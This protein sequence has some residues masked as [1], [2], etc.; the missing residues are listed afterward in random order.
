TTDVVLPVRSGWD[1]GAGFA[2]GGRAVCAAT[3]GTA[4]V[5]AAGAA[6]AGWSPPAAGLACG[7]VCG[8]VCGVAARLASGGGAL[9]SFAPGFVSS[10]I[11]PHHDKLQI[12]NGKSQ[13]ER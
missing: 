2:A 1:A 5:A 10:A 6:V 7:V 9:G 8:V 12:G 13:I 4:P 11:L 3:V